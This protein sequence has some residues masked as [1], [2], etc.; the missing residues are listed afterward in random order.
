VVEWKRR[1]RTTDLTPGPS[2]AGERGDNK[3]KK[4]FLLV[5]EGI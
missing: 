4:P 2:P 5:K 1:V 3:K